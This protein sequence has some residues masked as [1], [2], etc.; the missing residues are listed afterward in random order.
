MGHR[1]YRFHVGF[2][3]CRFIV[4][5]VIVEYAFVKVWSEDKLNKKFVVAGNFV[6]IKGGALLTF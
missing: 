4:I 2:C 6:R 5:S 3:C 1:S